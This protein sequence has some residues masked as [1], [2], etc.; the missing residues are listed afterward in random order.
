DRRK[1]KTCG[2]SSDSLLPE[3]AARRKTPAAS[4]LPKQNHSGHDKP[5]RA[6]VSPV[7]ERAGQQDGDQGSHEERRRALEL[8]QPGTAQIPSEEQ[9]RREGEDKPDRVLQR[10]KGLLMRDA[11]SRKRLRAA[12][13]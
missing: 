1:Q 3:M 10:H 2:E 13:A 9:H 4:D 5:P 8:I 11:A 7:A 12:L 6:R